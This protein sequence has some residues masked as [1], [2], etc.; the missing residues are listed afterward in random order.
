MPYT[1]EYICKVE[2]CDKRRW[3]KLYCP[4]HYRRY[5]RWG[6][7][8]G[9]APHGNNLKHTHC[10]VDGCNKKHIAKGMCQMHYRRY[11]L[12]GDV[13]AKPGKAK[14]RKGSVIGSGYISL[15]APTHP[16]AKL[17]G[18]ILEHRKVMSDFL[19]RPLVSGENVHHKNGDRSD[20]RLENLELWSTSQPQGQRAEDKVQY[21]VEIL[22]RYAPHL[23]TDKETQ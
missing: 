12:Y 20:N 11:T 6:D 14:K 3:N 18:T 22:K 15:Y 23:L 7:P 5:I 9:N 21:A 17:D 16:N 2:D 4:K 8:L 13:N 19:G 1:N 10:T